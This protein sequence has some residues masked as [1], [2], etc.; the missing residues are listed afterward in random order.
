MASP[1]VFINLHQL[2]YSLIT[3]LRQRFL[4]AFNQHHV[5]AAH[6]FR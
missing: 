2:K 3:L 5:Q 6:T 4:H 1:E